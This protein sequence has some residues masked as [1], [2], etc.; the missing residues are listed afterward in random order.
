MKKGFCK[1][2]FF[3]LFLLAFNISCGIYRFNLE[4]SATHFKKRNID[5]YYR[6]ALI[7]KFF[8]SDVPQWLNF[9][10]SGQCFR[11]QPIKFFHFQKLKGSFGLT[12]NEAI[13]FQDLYNEELR[14]SL[15]KTRLKYLPFKEE[16][17]IF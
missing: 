1:N 6:S 7:S 14:K 5:E 13:H 16:E 17:K 10:E 9:S 11:D 15:S 12:Y 2:I 4:N 8:L 3:V